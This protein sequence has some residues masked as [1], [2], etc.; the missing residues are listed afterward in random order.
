M[1]A[2]KELLKIAYGLK[3]PSK[4]GAE[5]LVDL[6]SHNKTK[7]RNISMQDMIL[8]SSEVLKYPENSH[9]L[10]AYRMAFGIPSQFTKED[11]FKL[12]PS[13]LVMLS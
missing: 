3:D 1:K 13:P 7:K 4:T 10:T 11:H 9:E 5:S 12:N 8:V 2:S 6:V